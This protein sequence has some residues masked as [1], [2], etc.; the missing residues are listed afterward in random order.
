V[1]EGPTVKVHV[2][3]GDDGF[4]YWRLKAENGEIIAD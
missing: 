3:Q 1:G 2:F 4:W